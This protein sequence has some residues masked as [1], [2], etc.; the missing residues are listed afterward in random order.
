M[1]CCAPEDVLDLE[2]V[3][4]ELQAKH[5]VVELVSAVASDPKALEPV[6]LR[7]R[8]QGVY[9][10]CRGEGLSRDAIDRLREVL[11]AHRVPFGRTLTV[12]SIRPQ[13]LLERIEAALRRIR[14]ALPDAPPAPASARPTM[15]G[16]PFPARPERRAEAA[17]SVVEP[18]DSRPA[19]VRREDTITDIAVSHEDT[20]ATLAPQQGPGEPPA[21]LRDIEFDE[22]T[23]VEVP[24]ALLEREEQAALAPPPPPRR[25]STA[26][27]SLTNAPLIT[28]ED[29]AD[30]ATESGPIAVSSPSSDKTAPPAF[31]PI[32][33]VLI[34]GDTA[35]ARLVGDGGH[36]PPAVLSSPAPV[37]P[38]TAPAPSIALEPAPSP[39]PPLSSPEAGDPPTQTRKSLWLGLA[40]LGTAGL[41]IIAW[42]WSRGGDEAPKTASTERTEP[43]EAA[44]EAPPEPEL[45]EAREPPDATV[46]G[47]LE[48]RVMAALRN[49]EVRAL[50]VLL[51]TKDD[52]PSL[53]YGDAEA[54]CRT[55]S[56][57][58]LDAWRL[59]EI[60]ELASMTEA[61]MLGKGIYWS[62]TPGDTFGDSRFAWHGRLERVLQR[63]AAS[64]A[65]C[66]RGEHVAR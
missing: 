31:A 48:T 59:P 37:R 33:K 8:G 10:L 32:S 50:D 24:H 7:L 14:G 4:R 60:G 19:D 15:L 62:S 17:P 52:G 65:L 26:E 42:G 43:Q 58:G 9:V 55:L 53:E 46:P 28:A 20:V 49:R 5:G 66:V 44:E 16:V 1:I 39:T 11:L 25:R 2:A 41:L 13:E 47:Q 30:L 23:T 21:E 3:V 40:A 36:T 61:G 35:I 12:A 64:H 45:V 6:L 18:D 63:D 54:Y 56:V 57:S 34:T 27:D 22:L 38:V 29:L 51:V